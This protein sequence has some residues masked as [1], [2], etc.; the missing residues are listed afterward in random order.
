MNDTTGQDIFII[1]T[2]GGKCST[3]TKKAWK[4]ISNTNHRTELLGYQDKGLPKCYPIVNAITKVLF[5]DRDPILLQINYAT[6]IDDP[7]EAESLFVPFESM[8]HGIKFNFTPAIFGGEPGMKI[9]DDFIPFNFD[10]EKLFVNIIY[11]SESDLQNLQ[12]FELT[13]LLTPS[14]TTRRKKSTTLPGD[15]P[16]SEWRKRLAMLPE[17]VIKKTLEA[18]TNFYLSIEGENR[19]DPRRHFQSRF[20]GLRIQRQNEE[21]ATDTFYPTVTTQRGNTCSQFFTGL[22]SKRWF[23]Y[24]IKIESH[25]TTALKDFVRQ[26]G[27]PQIIKSDNAQSEL[28]CD[29][30]EYMRNNCI[31]TKTTEPHH[32]HQNPAESEIGKLNSM[33]RNCQ[34]TFNVPAKMHDWTQK[35]CVDCHNIAANRQ[36]NWR[37]PLEMSTGNTPDISP[38]R[39]HIWEPIW[40]FVPAKPPDNCWKKGRWLGFAPNCGDCMTY[41]IYT[42]KDSHQGRN[43]VLVRS[44][45]KSRRT[46]IGTEKQYVCDESHDQGKDYKGVA[47]NDHDPINDKPSDKLIPT[48][49]SKEILTEIP[50]DHPCEDDNEMEQEVSDEVGENKQKLKVRIDGDLFK[51]EDLDETIPP[52]DQGD[53]ELDGDGDG[54]IY[55]QFEVEDDEHYD[56]EIIIDHYFNEGVLILKVKYSGEGDDSKVFDVPFPTLKKDVPLELAR[57]I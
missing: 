34:R 26:H 7:D 37:T 4:V 13:S 40:Y 5:P 19:M 22:S 54:E 56:F 30:I 1:D 57:Y 10:G 9:E 31:G 21:V 29:W 24:P 43:M 3:I 20:P 12:I 51:P 38:F 8:K 55:D 28:G 35:W 16:M 33:V 49:T 47:E 27:A 45:I 25:N 14:T 17:D 53:K 32:P 48:P 2:G 15:I 11:P 52:E 44:I 50:T 39:F 41:Y 46:N 18:T 36:L 23:V 6:L 42:E